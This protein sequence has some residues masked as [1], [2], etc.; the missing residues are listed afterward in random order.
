M[1][2]ASTHPRM[3]KP[4]PYST[5]V[6][7]PTP[8]DWDYGSCFMMTGP[9]QRRLIFWLLGRG[10]GGIWRVEDIGRAAR[11][12]GR[13][14]RHWG[15]RCRDV[16]GFSVRG[17]KDKHLWESERLDG[18]LSQEVR[19]YHCRGNHRRE[20]DLVVLRSAASLFGRDQPSTADRKILLRSIALLRNKV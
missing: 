1:I 5:S 3:H 14:S 11:L 19:L 2:S 15:P 6:P 12:T 18:N 8:P 9:G 10:W 13:W 16:Q 20:A 4:H 17:S 7:P